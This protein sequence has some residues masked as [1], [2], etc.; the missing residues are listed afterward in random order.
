MLLKSERNEVTFDTKLGYSRLGK[1]GTGMHLSC[2]KFLVIISDAT[3]GVVNPHYFYADPDPSFDFNADPESDPT[4]HFNADPIPAPQ[5][6]DVILR[7]W[8][9]RPSTPPM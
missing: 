3:G 6:S 1:T 5:Q 8:A 4:F 9:Y 7:P 2:V